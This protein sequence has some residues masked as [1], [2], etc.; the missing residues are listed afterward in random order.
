MTEM[1]SFPCPHCKAGL[2]APGDAAGRE[3]RCNQCQKPFIV[4]AQFFFDEPAPAPVKKPSPSSA[5]VSG[6]PAGGKP[7]AAPV[8]SGPGP[9]FVKPEPKSPAQAQ[10]SSGQKQA[11]NQVSHVASL[12][13]LPLIA[14]VVLGGIAWWFF[15]GD[16]DEPK[17]TNDVAVDAAPA[18]DSSADAAA[19]EVKRL[20]AEQDR[21]HA[22]KPVVTPAVPA[23]AAVAP[24]AAT[25]ILATSAA[26]AAPAAA[27]PAAVAEAPKGKSSIADLVEQFGP[28][29][30]VVK[31]NIGSGAGFVAFAADFIV[32]NYHVVSGSQSVQVVF[33]DGKNTSTHTVAVVAIDADNDL[34]L[35]RLS[36]PSKAKVLELA[37]DTGLRAGA[38]VFAIGSPGLG[39]TILTQSVSNGIISN[40]ERLIGKQKF[41]QTNTAINPG[42]SGGPLFDLEGKVVGVVSAK[43][44][45]QE[46]IGFAV[47]SSLVKVFYREREKRYRVDGEFIAWE[48][49]QPFER[50]KRHAGAIPLNT[51]PTDLL[52]DA[53]RD[54]LIGISPETNK[55]IFIDLKSRKVVREVFTG[56]DPVDLR[57]GAPGEVWVANRTSKSL[58]SLDLVSGKVTKT[59][60]VVHEPLA[61]TIGRKALWFMDSTG[62]AIVIKNTGKDESQT[63]LHIRSLSIYGTGGN[64]LC[65]SATSWLCEFDPDKVQLVVARRRSLKIAIDDFNAG[66]KVGSSQS[67]EAKRQGL[68]KD[69]ADTEAILTKAIKVYNQPA[70]TD[71][72]FSSKQQ[73]L[74]ID[75][76]R[77]R[78]YF[79]RCVMDLKEPGKIIGVFKSPE[80]SLKNNEAVRAFF[81]KYPYLNQIRAVS[82]DGTVAVSGTHIYN[83]TDFTIIAELPVP[84][85]SVVFHTDN[86]TL[87][88]GDPVNNQVVGMEY[89]PKANE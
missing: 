71:I 8:R 15:S 44:I 62:E 34:A 29:V 32:T 13:A 81:T 17:A 57:F 3:A 68:L 88:F 47:P 20:R 59:I 11:L 83:A 77:K 1:M 65:G 21:L 67:S 54:Q 74:F 42:N 22:S 4:P 79:N 27:A 78:I 25:P 84:T 82:P 5:P 10:S 45:R 31:T 41:I 2:K 53:E 69:L 9:I 85:S 76:P 51:Y 56:T 50:L 37:A 48:G 49:K 87:Y 89:R 28:S 40:T 33:I 55:V 70:G 38:E 12:L 52:L 26:A 24:S 7:G 66:V 39:A 80:H 18:T 16:S 43:A 30:V 64:I 46:N 19:A 73:R 36:E 35:L 72:D 14:L 75:E 86:K 63:D 58:V 61:F 6:K 23:T 60:S